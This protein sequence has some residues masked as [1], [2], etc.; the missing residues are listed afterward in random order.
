[1]LQ[2]NFPLFNVVGITYI[3]VM[4]NSVLSFRLLV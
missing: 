4:D 1:M 3:S 2:A